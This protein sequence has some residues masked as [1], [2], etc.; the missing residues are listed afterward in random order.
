MIAADKED[1]RRWF[2]R[3]VEE[4]KADAGTTIDN[5]LFSRYT[6][7]VKLPRSVSKGAGRLLNA[8]EGLYARRW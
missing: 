8:K 6:L 4:G 5:Y 1:I 3:G 7:T 2:D